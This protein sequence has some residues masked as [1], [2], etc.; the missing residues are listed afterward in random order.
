MAI[1]V[2]ALLEEL[3]VAEKASLTSGSGFWYTAPVERLGIPRIMVSD[4]PH[5]LR[6]Q[7][8][9][10]D[11]VGLGGSLPA[12]CFPTASAVASTWNP[13]LLRRIG[14]ALAAGGAGVQPVGD[15][16]AGDQHEALAAVR[17]QLRVLLRRPLPGRGAGRRD[18][19]RDPVGRRG[20]VG[21]ALRRQQPGDRPAAG[22]RPGRR[23][24][25]AG[26]LLP[27]V[28]AD[29]HGLPAVDDHVLLQQGQRPLGLGEPLAAHHRAARGVRVRGPGRVRLGR[30]LPPGPGAAR[31][32]WTWRCR[33]T[34]RA[35]RTIAAAVGSASWPRTSSTPGSGRSWSWWQ[36]HGRCWIS[37]RSSTSTPT[38]RSLG[39]AAAESVVLLK[40][41]G[42][43]LPLAPTP[44]RGGRRVRPH[45]AVP[46]R[47]QLPGQPDPGR[48]RARRADRRVRRGHLRAGYGIDD[49]T[50]DDALRAEAVASPA[51]A[52]PWSC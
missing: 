40:N 5:G 7:P 24:H 1:D 6:A 13:E 3:T 10:G 27:G 36:G 34:C 46:G 28:R 31:P 39:A 18:R 43:I 12:T 47:R 15:P 25:A 16:G 50:D 35:A 33:P 26:D 4:G 14:E 23:A 44:D 21:E 32:G 48:Q 20:H 38:T 29:R 30:G 45:A 17:A 22:R 49:A 37:T 41:D 42:A 19:R 9:E 11:H 2:E 51:A 8:G 52:D